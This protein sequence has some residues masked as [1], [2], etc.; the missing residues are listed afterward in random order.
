MMPKH[1]K[2]LRD[3]EKKIYRES[4]LGL[5]GQINPGQSLKIIIDQFANQA[6]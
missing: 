4:Y 3:H 1:G 6:K 2:W 5:A